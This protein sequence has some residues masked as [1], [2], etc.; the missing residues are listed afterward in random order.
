MNTHGIGIHPNDGA[1]Q[2]PGIPS[3]SSIHLHNRDR[4]RVVPQV[5]VSRPNDGYLHTRGPYLQ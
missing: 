2:P 5:M 3:L 4:E 1:L